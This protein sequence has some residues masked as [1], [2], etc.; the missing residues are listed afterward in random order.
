M[1]RTHTCGELRKKDIKENITVCGWLQSSRD[2]G[3]IIFIDVRDRYGLT[4]IVFDPKHNKEAHK[5]A[6]KLGREYVL[7]VKGKVRA[8]G[9]GLENPKLNT[10][11]IEVLVDELNVLNKAEVPPI[12]VDDNKEASEDLRLK[13]RFLDLRRPMMQKRLDIRHKAA[14]ATRKYLNSQSFMEIETPLLIRATPEGARDYIVPSRTMPGRFFSLPQSPQLYKQILMVSGCDRYYQLARCL[15]DEDL[16][17]DRQPEFTQIDLEMSFAD[18]DDIMVMSEGLVKE[19]FKKGVG[20]NIKV[21]FQRMTY[22][23]VMERYGSDKPDLRYGLELT[24]VTSLVHKSDFGVF[25]NAEQ[26]KCINPEKDFSRKELDEYID[27]CIKNGA[28]GMAWM[29]ITDKGMESSVTKFFK[30][31][32]LKKIQKVANAKKG[33]LMFIADTPK[34][35]AEVLDRLR[36]KLADDLELYDKKELRFCW[37]T[38]FPLFE[39]DEESDSWVPMHHIFSMPH[40]K[41]V[42]KMEADPSVIT[43]KLYDCVLNGVELGGGSVRIH[44]KDVQEE[45]LKVIGMSYEEAKQ[46]FGFLLDSFRYGAPPHGGLAFGFD[47]VVALMC[48][49]S[50]IREVIAFPKNKNAECPMDGCPSSVDDNQLKELRIKTDVIKKKN[51]VLEKIREMLLKE[52]KE[53][54]LMEHE[55]VFT[56][57]QAAEVRGT[58]LKEGAKALVLK[59]EKG[60]I[61]AVLPGDKEIDVD[62]LK[63]I[64]RVSR[65]ELAAPE[66]V[67]KMSGCGVG[68]VPPFGNIFGIDLFVDKSLKENKGVNFNAGSHTTSIKMSSVA[69]LE[70]AK[71][72]EA[73]FC[74]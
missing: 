40:D 33:V 70:L 43:G 74:R 20:K 34:L 29:K 27:F 57:K 13:Y 44:K 25:K 11:D 63:K 36:R 12:E 32:M 47:R 55:P 4:Q 46:R 54:E 71:G 15:R 23:E 69:Y 31:E 72:K 30:P 24:D 42:G 3:G 73:E 48:G 41:F 59:S 17:A 28:K 45:A 49:I 5:K 39:H 21:P 56:C 51:M 62:K 38:D 14:E 61:M 2:H 7:Q 22:K 9:K 66:D 16:R 64:L 53:F 65:L 60:Y 67:K 26:V 68:S 8:R 52:K 1:L 50:D 10:G 37:V 18:E 58:P 35:V 6:E 19:I